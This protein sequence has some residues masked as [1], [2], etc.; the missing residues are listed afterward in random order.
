MG[1]GFLSDTYPDV[2]AA[3][4]GCALGRLLGDRA[5]I[6][7][8]SVSIGLNWTQSTQVLAIV[9]RGTQAIKLVRRPS[10][11]QL[12]SESSQGGD[13]GG[14]SAALIG[15]RIWGDLS[16]ESSPGEEGKGADHRGGGPRKWSPHTCGEGAR[17][18]EHLHSSR[19]SSD[20]IRLNQTQ[21]VAI[22]LGD[23]DGSRGGSGY[24]GGN[25]RWGGKGGRRGGWWGRRRW[26]LWRR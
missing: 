5:R 26:G 23:G 1:R 16:S 11:H 22:R 17:G 19:P 14:S 13:G 15:R 7:Q 12:R 20:A 6:T 8:Q 18:S 9:I 24:G 4:L 21:S 2:L 25:G 3:A 10:A